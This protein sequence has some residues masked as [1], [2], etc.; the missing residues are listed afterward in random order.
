MSVFYGMHAAGVWQ[1]MRGVNLLDGG[2]PFYDTYATKDG[3][4]VALG[5]L[6]AEFY[7]ALLDRLGIADEDASA[8]LDRTRWPEVRAKIAAVIETRTRDDW[9]A[10]LLGTDVCY[11]P[12]L[13]LSD[14]PQHPHNIARGLFVD[15]D[16]VT[17]PAPAPRFSNTSPEIQGPPQGADSE[18]VLKDW[19][20][21]DDEIAR[22]KTAEAI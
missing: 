13:S 7:R 6:E 22:L 17:Q 2:A 1:D 12:V 3:K 11:A 8:R 20:F 19:G 5:P 14:A 10:V 9:D 15:I 4:W 16:G 18:A 21:A